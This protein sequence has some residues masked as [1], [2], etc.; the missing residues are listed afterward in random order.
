[1]EKLIIITDM[2]G[3]EEGSF[4]AEDIEVYADSE[5]LELAPLLTCIDRV[6]VHYNYKKYKTE[7][8]KKEAPKAKEP[9]TTGA[10]ESP[11]KT[12]K[13]KPKNAE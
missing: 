9:V 8:R 11:K 12:N 13:K 2:N 3:K 5:G 6:Q 10:N 1:M 7:M 4:R